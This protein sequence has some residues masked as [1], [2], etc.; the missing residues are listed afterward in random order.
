MKKLSNE[1]YKQKLSQKNPWVEP[2]GE[3]TNATTPMLFRCKMCGREWM[4][5]PGQIMNGRKCRFCAI[6]INSNKR[7]KTNADFLAD[8]AVIN[9][10]VK[11][12]EEYIDYNTP[13]LVHC[14]LCG[15][16]WKASP[17]NLLAG[18]GCKL[19]ADK[20]GADKRRK[21]Q[22]EFIEALKG[23]NPDVELIGEYYMAAK[24]TIFRCRK[25]GYEWLAKPNHILSGHGCPVC[26]GSQRKE[27]ES[28]ISQLDSVNPFVDVLGEY[29]NTRTKI[30]CKCKICG[31]EWPIT[32]NSLLRG[33]GCPEC[34]KRNKTSFPEQAIFFYI[35]KLYPDAIN[36]YH[37]EI[38]RF[39]IDVF[40]PSIR[41]GIEYDGAYYH[42]SLQRDEKKYLLC[43]ETGI[44]LFRIMERKPASDKLADYV[45]QRDK[46]NNYE[47]LDNSIIELL[48][49]MDKQCEV[50]SQKDSI[51][52]REQYYRILE[53]KSISSKYPNI[54][55]EWLYSQNGKITPQMV[56]YGSPDKYWWKCSK[57]GNE[58]KAAVR[59]RTVGGKGCSICGHKVTAKK[60]TKSNDDF[61]AE[62][63]ESKPNILPLEEYQGYHT[64][65]QFRCLRCGNEWPAAPADVINRTDCPMCSRKRGAEK[66]SRKR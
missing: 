13:I 32:P 51:Q 49:F 38:G 33:S 7:R 2:L 65:I 56:S 63:K 23:K 59:D 14:Q 16:E 5:I 22:Q 55:E 61:V 53:E 20:R 36:R 24:K 27:H 30:T 52:I 10:S 1:E 54:A 9:S 47:T 46:P 11:P 35:K 29:I 8:L 18:K 4:A 45:I 21:T 41:V 64:K 39:E 15:N 44:R 40:I 31:Y 19:C 60:L 42:S 34:D 57:C 50:N 37:G 58:W 43:K 25:C 28:F 6:K 48:H 12:L 3:Y 62:L 26:G 66:R 17:N